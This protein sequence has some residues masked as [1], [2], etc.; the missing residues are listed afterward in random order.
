MSILLWGI[1]ALIWGINALFDMLSRAIGLVTWVSGGV[2]VLCGYRF[3][4]N[5][6]QY[7]ED[8]NQ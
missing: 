4:T 5:L 3:V 6:I 2:A 8:K 1:T 7:H